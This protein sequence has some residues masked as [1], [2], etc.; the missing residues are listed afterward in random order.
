MDESAD[1]PGVI[2]L[3]PFLYGGA[4][5]VV[6]V[7]RWFW[8]L[9]ILTDSSPLL[10][11]LGLIALGIALAIWGSRTMRAAG[12]NVNPS[13]PATALVASGPFRYSRNP[14][15]IALTLLFLG[16]TMAVNTWWGVLMLVPL[17]TVMHRG[18]IRREE[19]YLE[20]KFGESYR[21]Y[22]SKVRRYV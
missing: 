22:R 10:P 4:F 12:T 11:G 9:R 17:L 6:L 14:L 19:S 21:K 15:Y 1:N 7:L 8:P 13:L 3:P 5:L 20:Q 2:A 18:V 16:L